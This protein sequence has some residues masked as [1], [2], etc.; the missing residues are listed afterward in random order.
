MLSYQFIYQQPISNIHSHGMIIFV[1]YFVIL[2]KNT[3]YTIRKFSLWTYAIYTSSWLTRR[4]CIAVM[5]TILPIHI[6]AWYLSIVYPCYANPKATQWP[7][8]ILQF[9]ILNL[10]MYERYRGE[11]GLYRCITTKINK[12]LSHLSQRQ[13]RKF[14]WLG[15]TLTSALPQNGI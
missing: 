9:N 6:Y 2:S 3:K 4:N 7:C 12:W 10:I 15:R 13:M 14:L 8:Q 1:R 11:G 5:G